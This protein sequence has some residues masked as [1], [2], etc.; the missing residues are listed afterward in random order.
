VLTDDASTIRKQTEEL[1]NAFHA[2]SQQ[3][4]AQQ[5]SEPGSNGHGPHEHEDVEEGEEVVEGQFREI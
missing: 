4:Y 2:I 1:Q 3:M 5:Q